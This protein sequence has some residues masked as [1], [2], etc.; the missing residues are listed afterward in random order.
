MCLA[1]DPDHLELTIS[2]VILFESKTI[3]LTTGFTGNPQAS[4]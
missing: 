2:D 4:V 3:S 1:Y